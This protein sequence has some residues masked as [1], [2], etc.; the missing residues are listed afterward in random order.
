MERDA[1][2][3]GSDRGDETRSLPSPPGWPTHVLLGIACSLIVWATRVPL[4][5][6]PYLLTGLAVG[7]VVIL[8]WLVRA[9]ILLSSRLRGSPQ[10]GR[11]QAPWARWCIVPLSC[12]V[13]S[14]AVWLGVPFAVGFQI[15][16]PAMQRA[17]A[18]AAADRDGQRRAWV[19]VYPMSSIRS[20]PGG[21]EFTIAGT[22]FPWGERG[23]YY[24]GA[25]VGLENPHYRRQQRIDAHWFGWDYGGW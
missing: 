16:Q 15:S 12:A 25:G 17:V 5:D 9:L 20:I 8:V 13:L 10:L 21:V 4:G 14:I 7:A 2:Q 24:S 19:G 6:L 22:V 23:F 1:A 3:S 11:A 18:R